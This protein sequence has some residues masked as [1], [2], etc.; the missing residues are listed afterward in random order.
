MGAWKLA[1]EKLWERKK[2]A[3]AIAQPRLRVRDH[4]TQDPP[5]VG[6][7]DALQTVAHLLC[8]PDIRAVPVVENGQ[9]V[10][11]ITDRDLRQVAPAYSLLGDEEEIRR[12]LEHLTVTATMTA[13][14]V[15]I[16]PDAPLVDAAKILEAYRFSSLPVTEGANLIGLISVNDVLRAFIEQN[17]EPLI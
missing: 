15:T 13:N 16:A 4:M 10:G 2:S 12:Y 6:P 11:I 17:E 1:G 3:M 5:A 14:P 7:G 9:V 8:H